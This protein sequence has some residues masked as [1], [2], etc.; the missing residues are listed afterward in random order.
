MM[1]SP[2]PYQEE[3]NLEYGGKNDK[4]SDAERSLPTPASSL[5]PTPANTNP[6]TVMR[7]SGSTASRIPVTKTSEFIGNATSQWIPTPS[8]TAYP[9]TKTTTCL[10][11]QEQDL[12]NYVGKVQHSVCEE[13]SVA[14]SKE[15]SESE[16]SSS[17]ESASEASTSGCS[18]PPDNV[19]E[20]GLLS[21]FQDSQRRMVDRLMQEVQSMLDQNPEAQ[22]RAGENETRGKGARP[23]SASNNVGQNQ[24][25]RGR[26]RKVCG[27]PAEDD[28]DDTRDGRP[29]KRAHIAVPPGLGLEVRKFACQYYQRNPQAHQNSRSC[30]G[31]G[32]PTVH[33]LK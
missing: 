13:N 19:A 1:T 6:K 11:P 17:F 28:E 5:N 10:E 3:S 25:N 20:S 22:R 8:T 12:Q 32:W 7:Y 24:Q 4:R 21:A 9:S 29:D 23:S 33:R 26:K 15:E 2:E 27:S 30:G 16:D 31:P 18:T 14:A